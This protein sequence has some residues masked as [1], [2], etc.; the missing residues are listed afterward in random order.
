[1]NDEIKREGF[2]YGD[3][4]VSF[5]MSILTEIFSASTLRGQ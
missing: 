3:D 5:L 2:L 4:R 1:M